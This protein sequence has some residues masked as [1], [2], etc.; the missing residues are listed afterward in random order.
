[1]LAPRLSLAVPALAAD[2]IVVADALAA[3]LA[4]VDLLPSVLALA[5]LFLHCRAE[6]SKR[7]NNAE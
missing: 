1:V 2:A 7:Y 3:T 4:A 5:V 6:S